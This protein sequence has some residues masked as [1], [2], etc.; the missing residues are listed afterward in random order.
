[1][2]LLRP[3]I[4]LTLTACLATAF[5]AHGFKNPLIAGVPKNATAFLSID[6]SG[7]SESLQSVFRLIEKAGHSS[8]GT[9]AAHGLEML[10]FKPDLAKA[11]AAQMNWRAMVY[12]D[13]K[14]GHAGIEKS[15]VLLVG[16]KH[17]APV[18]RVLSGS[19]MQRTGD[20]AYRQAST[21]VGAK[22]VGNTLVLALDPRSLPSA[23][24]T[25][26]RGPH[27]AAPGG[28]SIEPGAEIVAWV[29]GSDSMLS[30]HPGRR[31]LGFGAGAGFSLALRPKG[32]SLCVG[33]IQPDKS[34][35]KALAGLRP[36]PSRLVRHLPGGPYLITCLANPMPLLRS[37]LHKSGSNAKDLA[38]VAPFLSSNLVVG[39]YPTKMIHGSPS[40]L[41]LLLECQSTAGNDPGRAV[42]RLIAK[43][44][45]AHG[46]DQ[47]VIES[48]SLPG[49]TIAYRLSKATASGLRSALHSG[50]GLQ[51]GRLG[52]LVDG[53]NLECA[54]VGRSVILATSDPVLRKAVIALR[55]GRNSLAGDGK[56]AEMT[57]DPHSAGM[58][59]GIS[60]TRALTGAAG[61]LK[62]S[63]AVKQLKVV[64]D[65]AATW[66]DPLFLR[67]SANG[68][69][70]SGRLFVP[71]DFKALSA[72]VKL[73]DD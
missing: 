18:A 11:V 44:K 70:I 52:K 24:K 62:D 32:V 21:A 38:M 10:Q 61:L 69:G 57:R 54:I 49:A 48:F 26:R 63:S 12:I 8:L 51:G 22:V 59:L 73:A 29:V 25:L 7:K 41:D 71:I 15:A 23:V 9:A 40:G 46:G 30:I 17:G 36:L 55:Y 50:P 5:G 56:F 2:R 14:N 42:R 60:L 66:P 13:A 47:P 43:A 45:K 65:L 31:D 19:P 58:L 6:L 16:L 33:P 4:C 67:I 20:L 28:D 68:K 37:Q 3:C 39:L 64:T 35:R 34:I 27:I 53:K 72:L 1:M